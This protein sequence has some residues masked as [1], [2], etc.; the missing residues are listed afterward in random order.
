MDR[1]PNA[2]KQIRGHLIDLHRKRTFPAEIT[3]GSGRILSVREIPE[4]PQVWILPGFVDAH[5]HIESS[6]LPPSAFAPLALAQGTLATVSDP[7]EIANVLGEEGVRWMYENGKNAPL[8]FHFGA[9]SCVPATAFETAGDEIDAE[10]IRR[11]LSDGT[12]AYL[13]EMMNWPGVIFGDELVKE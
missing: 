6:M 13:A 5:V 2:Q 11:L 1:N 12:C 9:P 4:A 8:H 10:A 7:H 3:I